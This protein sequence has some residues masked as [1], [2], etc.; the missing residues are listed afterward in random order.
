LPRSGAGGRS[1][2]QRPGRP[3]VRRPAAAPVMIFSLLRDLPTGGAR[4]PRKDR[5]ITGCQP[6]AT[7]V[8][9]RTYSS[10]GF[11]APCV[12]RMM[13]AIGPTDYPDRGSGDGGR[14]DILTPVR[15]C[16]YRRNRRTYRPPSPP[17]SA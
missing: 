6:P 5:K 16:R 11:I 10:H 9:A 15:P 17:R 2:D 14:T 4:P 7:P 3:R 8:D 1:G 13:A 12:F